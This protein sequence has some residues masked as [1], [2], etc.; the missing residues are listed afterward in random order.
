[1]RLVVGKRQRIGDAAAGEG[2]AG[3][4]FQEREVFNLPRQSG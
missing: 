4:C 3:L 2:Q 1:M